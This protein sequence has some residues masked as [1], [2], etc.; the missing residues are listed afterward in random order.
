MTGSGFGDLP[1]IPNFRDVGG[2]ATQDGH[3]V[4]RGLLYRG[5]S[6][7]GL[8]A[9]QAG[10]VARL[11]LRSVYDFRTPRERR[12]R[13]DQLAPGVSYLAVDVLGGSGHGLVAK[14]MRSAFDPGTAQ[15]V[16]GNGQGVSLW[17]EQY[18]DFVRLESAALAFGR[19][20]GEI[21]DSARRPALC[22]CA[23]GKDRTGWAAAALSLFLG[24]SFQDVM[25]DFLLSNACLAP[26]LEQ[27]AAQFS[28]RGGDPELLDPLL[29]VRPAYLEVACEEVHLR[30]GTIE[31]YFADGLRLD[32]GQRRSLRD[33]F[34]TVSAD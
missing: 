10:A 12:E 26:Q 16:L 15:E 22:H 23:T 7:H 1:A 27:I 28:A 2:H 17:L 18:R 5:G 11:G 9:D 32:T 13:P 4:R 3:R 14:L 24:V 6:L 21:A 30:F 34:L 8:S 25:A 20:F 29:R 33:A 19:V 31:G